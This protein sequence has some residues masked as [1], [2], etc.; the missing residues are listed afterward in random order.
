M[1]DI[2][3]AGGFARLLVF[4]QQAFVLHRHGVAGKRHHA[5]TQFQVQGV[6]GSQLQ[7]SFR[8][9]MGHGVSLS[10]KDRQPARHRPWQAGQ[11]PLSL[12]PER[13]TA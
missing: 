1:G 8:R 9:G 6:E 12:V 7:I 4:G 10:Q 11:A 3:Q 13:F 2:E 5:G